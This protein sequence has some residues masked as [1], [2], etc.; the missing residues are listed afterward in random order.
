[1]EG[2]DINQLRRKIRSFLRKKLKGEGY[3]RLNLEL[4]T[5][6]LEFLILFNNRVILLNKRVLDPEE[7][8][9]TMH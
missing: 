5:Y 9:Y 6:L 4:C 8:L 3:L 1:M 7:A 2:M